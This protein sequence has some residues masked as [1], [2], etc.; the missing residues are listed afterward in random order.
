[1]KFPHEKF[2][3]EEDVYSLPCDAWSLPGEKEPTVRY[4]LASLTCGE[5]VDSDPKTGRC[6]VLDRMPACMAFTPKGE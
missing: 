1:M 3:Y 2:I 4:L 5:C 6:D